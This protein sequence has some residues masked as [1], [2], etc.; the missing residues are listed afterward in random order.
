MPVSST[1]IKISFAILKSAGFQD[2]R[3]LECGNVERLES[4][5]YSPGVNSGDCTI[6]LRSRCTLSP[7]VEPHVQAVRYV[8]R[9]ICVE[10]ARTSFKLQVFVV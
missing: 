6:A 9:S 5:S 10:R 2:S 3:N 7:P 4:G 8:D 1:V